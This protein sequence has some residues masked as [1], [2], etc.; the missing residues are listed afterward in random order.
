[1]KKIALTCIALCA[2]ISAMAQDDMY[3]VPTKK[4]IQQER[5]VNLGYR[6]SQ[7]YD[8]PAES[9]DHDNWA[10]GRNY[11]NRNVDE[12]NRRGVR[13]KTADSLRSNRMRYD[14]EA[15]Y[16]ATSR[17]VRFRSPGITIVTSPYYYDY[18]DFADYDPWIDD[19]AWG[20]W[21]YS[22]DPFYYN[23][24]STWYSPWSYSYNYWGSP[25]YFGASW[26]YGWYGSYWNYGWNSPYYYGGWGAPYYYYDSPRWYSYARPSHSVTYGTT[27]GRNSRG[28][29]FNNEYND[30]GRGVVYGNTRSNANYARDNG[31]N[32]YGSGA[33]YRGNRVNT[34]RMN[35]SSGSYSTSSRSYNSNSSTYSNGATPYQGSYQR[36]G[37]VFGSGSYSG[38]SGYSGGTRSSGSYS[39]G[40]YS[41]GSSGGSTRQ[42]GTIVGGRR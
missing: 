19:W 31:V 2:A 41:G 40:G 26:R 3:F 23:R 24:W 15:P 14:D 28:G 29:V 30:W 42:G 20:G 22:Y 32:Y 16:T 10:D 37:S 33:S 8:V 4:A 25:F 21:R 7:V 9:F 12:Y 1:M 5:E 36:S 35:S 18:Y 39:G 11:G 34:S 27:S 6:Q 13:S 38:G 17:I